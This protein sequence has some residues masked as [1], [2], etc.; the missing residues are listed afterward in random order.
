M[1]RLILI[2][3]TSMLCIVASTGARAQTINPRL[4]IT[5]VPTRLML[6]P[7]LVV[8][9][10]VVNVN[11]GG[12]V[13][14]VKITVT[15]T[16]GV[17]APT[18]YV[19]ATFMDK[20]GGKALYIIGNTVKALKGGESHEQ[21]F[22]VSERKMPAYTHVS[23]EVDPF[24]TLKEDVEGNNYRKRQPNMFPFPDGPNH[25]KPKG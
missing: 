19:H 12:M 3:L 24:K 20:F 25:C 15:N 14:S 11:P 5:K 2:V 13:E 1:K 7:D 9:E 17:A 21:L 16:C 8:S 4:K 22:N 23:A 6:L 10:V 18:S